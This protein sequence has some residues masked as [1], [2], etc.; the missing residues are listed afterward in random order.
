MLNSLEKLGLTRIGLISDTHGYMDDR[1]LHHLNECNE[2]WHAGDIGSIELVDQINE[3]G[4][5]NNKQVRWVHGNIDDHKVRLVCPEFNRFNVEKVEILM[6]HIAG[7]PGKYSLALANELQ[8]NGS[9]TILV[10]GHSHIL[11][12][13][14]DNHHNMLWLNPG[15]CGN[16]GFHRLRTMIRF[17]IEGDKIQNLEAI[18]LGKR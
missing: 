12:V 13:K 18:E 16:K 9:P 4:K 6:T 10:C 17:E 5:N 15:A 3:F 8:N 7:K 2:I 11:L 14:K 1:I